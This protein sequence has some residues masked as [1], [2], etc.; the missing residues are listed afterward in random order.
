VSESTFRLGRT[1]FAGFTPVD[2]PD[3]GDELRERVQGLGF[4]VASFVEQPHLEDWGALGLSEQRLGVGKDAQLSQATVSRSYT[5]WR[6]PQGRH[7]PANLAELGE[8][9]RRSLDAV[10]P[11]PRPEWLVQRVERMRYPMLWEAIQTHWSAPGAPER[12]AAELLVEHIQ[13]VLNNQFR[14]EHALPPM[15]GQPWAELVG[16]QGVE[17]GHPVTIDGVERTGVLL[18]TDPFVIGIGATLDDG[19]VLTAAIPRAELPLLQIE[20]VS[21]VLDLG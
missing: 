6:D 11:R 10:P 8:K 3:P 5:L 7:D 9:P 15:T 14:V 19:R 17:H 20:F 18:D 21:S 4:G 16:I 12:S 2:A 1:R 13:H